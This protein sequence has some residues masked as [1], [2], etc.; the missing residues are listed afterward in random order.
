MNSQTEQVLH[1]LIS[2]SQRYNHWL[3]RAEQILGESEDMQHG[4]LDHIQELQTELEEY[5]YWYGTVNY[6]LIAEY[7]LND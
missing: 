2:N 3:H 7:L 1:E 4:D 6:R 5:E